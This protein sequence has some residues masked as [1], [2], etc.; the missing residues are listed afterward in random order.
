MEHTLQ[1][2]I[3]WFRFIALNGFR[4]CCQGSD[5]VVPTRRDKMA[6]SSNNYDK[7]FNFSTYSSGQFD[8]RDTLYELS[9]K[10]GE[11]APKITAYDEIKNLNGR[12]E[13]LNE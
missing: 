12:P 8:L 5:P 6:N 2:R 9:I 4:K 3:S 10:Y 11:L 7:E 1:H 13:P